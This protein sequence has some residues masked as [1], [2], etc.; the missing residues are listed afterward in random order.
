M[1]DC[2]T[3]KTRDGAFVVGLLITNLIR[4]NHIA[5]TLLLGFAGLRDTENKG[6]CICGWVSNNKL[7][8]I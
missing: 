7:N 4:H 5:K 3:Q 2:G 6:R 8:K 1:R